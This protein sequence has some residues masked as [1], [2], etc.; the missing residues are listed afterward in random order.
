MSTCT[1]VCI[2][3]CVYLHVCFFLMSECPQKCTEIH[4]FQVIRVSLLISFYVVVQ[5]F[6]GKE[7]HLELIQELRTVNALQREEQEL[8]N[9]DKELVMTLT[10][11]RDKSIHKVEHI[12]T[13]MFQILQ[14][15]NKQSH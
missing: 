14:T 1:C 13:L 12:G 7:N 5:M 11:Q 15:T 9:S 6:K 10:Q 2:C 3:V 4:V 8:Q